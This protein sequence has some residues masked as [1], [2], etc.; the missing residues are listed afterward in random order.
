MAEQVKNR[1]ST[2]PP[3]TGWHWKK[4]T[5]QDRN[6][7]DILQ[8]PTQ[9]LRRKKDLQASQ[10]YHNLFQLQLLNSSLMRVKQAG[11][12]RSYAIPSLLE[13]T[14][15]KPGVVVQAT[16]WKRN[17]H[18]TRVKLRFAAPIFSFQKSAQVFTGNKINSLNWEDNW[19]LTLVVNYMS[20]GSLHELWTP[21]NHQA[22]RGR[23]L[24]TGV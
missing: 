3:N 18:R 24:R 19:I 4:T 8:W 13:I 17:S 20:M 22:I 16:A 6:L 1:D 15:G 21:C 5:F 23:A 7:D 11:P 10:Y 12:F 2:A 14:T 9:K